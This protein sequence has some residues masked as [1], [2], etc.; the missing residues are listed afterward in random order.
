[1]RVARIQ[2]DGAAPVAAIE[3]DGILQPLAQDV[4]ALIEGAAPG[5]LFDAVAGAKRLAPV[6]P[7]KVVAIGLNYLDHIRESGLETPQ[8]PLVFAKFPS[9]VIGG[10]EPIRL[11]L[12]LTQRVDWE[13]ELAVVIGRR[14][15]NVATEDALGHVYG[16]TVA[17]DVSARDLQFADG[18]WVRAKSL[19]SFC[20]IGPVLVTADEIPD[21]QALRLLCRVNGEVVQDATTD[22]MV[23]GV[24][25]LI[26]FCSHSFTLDPGD[27]LLT[28]TPWGCGE[29]MDPRRSL[30]PGDVVECEI[31]GIGTLRN[32]VV[33]A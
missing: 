4:P 22:L 25:E 26:S 24:A 32:P 27:V 21:P 19:D 20:P 11:P 15:R 33:E 5:D 7:G 6:V 18:Q 12:D 8:R 30:A 10:D 2:I 23:F 31:G 28:G 16:Y 13:V 1:L 3:R 17:N 14:A 29:F 9:S